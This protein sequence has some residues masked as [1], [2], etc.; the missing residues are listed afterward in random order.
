VKKP[1]LVVMSLLMTML[2]ADEDSCQ[3]HGISYTK[4]KYGDIFPCWKNIPEEDLNKKLLAFIEP[5]KETRQAIILK[6]PYETS[7]ILNA[8]VQAGFTFHCGD[9][10]QLTWIVK[11]RASIP[12]PFTAISGVHVVILKEDKI[13]VIEEKTRRGQLGFPA[14][15]SES[16]EFAKETAQRE[17]YEETGL[18]VQPADLKLIALINRKRAN[19]QGASLLDHCFLAENVSGKLH[20]DPVE[21]IQGFWVSVKDVAK[22]PEINGLKVSP[23]IKVLAKHILHGCSSSY[24]V[25]FPDNRQIPITIDPT[26]TM[27]VEFFHQNLGIGETHSELFSGKIYNSY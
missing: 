5:F 18:S 13:L 9:Q 1:L 25:V 17:L 19:E 15:G 24:S 6:I 27:N 16:G 11:N 3:M 4:N 21:I 10:N 2:H 23:Y 26:D 20:L 8:V 14:G 7:S 12:Q 22:S